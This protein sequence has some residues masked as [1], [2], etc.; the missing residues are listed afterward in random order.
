[1]RVGNGALFFFVVSNIFH[2]PF[3]LRQGA[4]F[5][6]VGPFGPA[7]FFVSLSR[8]RVAAGVHQKPKRSHII[9]ATGTLPLPCEGESLTLSNGETLSVSGAFVAIGHVPQT[10]FLKGSLD[11]D[12][13]GYVCTNGVDT[14]VSGVFVE[15]DCANPL[16][17]QAVVAASTGAQTA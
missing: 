9:Q 15:G 7:A 10:D 13:E 4:F 8:G 14:S 6:V 12:D 2:Q 17:R 1:M 11:L 3:G 16:Y 5:F